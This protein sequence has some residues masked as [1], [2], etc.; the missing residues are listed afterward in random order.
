MSPWLVAIGAGLAFAFLQY[1]WRRTHRGPI[2]FA[3]AM[4]R[5][6]AAA[7]VV[8]LLLDAP[9]GRARPVSTWAALDVSQSMIRGDSALWKA[10]RDS[11]NAVHADST[12]WFGDST[13]A[14]RGDGR[15]DD[16]RSE[17]RPVADRAVAAGHPV[18]LITDG[19]IADP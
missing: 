10:A 14:G 6:I 7:L 9:A 3:A 5:L 1:G 2:W 18:A 8:A 19:E 4:L 12:L 15:A 16:R 17:V 13:R 11:A